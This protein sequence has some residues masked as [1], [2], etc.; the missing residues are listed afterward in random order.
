MYDEPLVLAEIYPSTLASED[1][2]QSDEGRP[3]E[4][5]EVYE[6]IEDD[7]EEEDEPLWDDSPLDEDEED[8]EE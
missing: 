7:Y 4:S 8:E 5:D 2:P 6:E 1:D 3:S